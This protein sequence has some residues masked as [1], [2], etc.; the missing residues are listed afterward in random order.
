MSTHLLLDFAELSV[1]ARSANFGA[2]ARLQKLN[3]IVQKE[4]RAHLGYLEGLLQ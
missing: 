2:V 4:K 1:G 3:K